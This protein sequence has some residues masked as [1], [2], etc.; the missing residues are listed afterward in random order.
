MASTVVCMGKHVGGLNDNATSND[1]NLG[2]VPMFSGENIVMKG[3]EVKKKIGEQTGWWIAQF[4]SAVWGH[5]SD[6]ALFLEDLKEFPFGRIERSNSLDATWRIEQEN[7]LHAGVVCLGLRSGVGG[8]TA[9][10]SIKP[11]VEKYYGLDREVFD[12]VKIQL[13]GLST[14]KDDS[15]SMKSV[16]FVCKIGTI[17]R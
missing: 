4:D 14:L 10:L 11:Q 1:V 7:P 17:I 15:Y 6:N 13:T 5:C 9:Y 2:A 3:G 8:A 12:L 16:P